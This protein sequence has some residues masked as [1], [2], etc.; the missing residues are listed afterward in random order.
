MSTHGLEMLHPVLM[1][2]VTHLMQ[3]TLVQKCIE[4]QNICCG[5]LDNYEELPMQLYPRVI[6]PQQASLQWSYHHNVIPIFE[7]KLT[8]STWPLQSTYSRTF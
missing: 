4:Y 3:S 8:P 5:T 1:W 7:S 2:S 6:K